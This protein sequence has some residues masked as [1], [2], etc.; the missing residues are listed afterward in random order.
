MKSILIED[1]LAVA[2]IDALTSHICVVN[3]AGII[4]AVNQAWT[5]FTA[6]NSTGR[7]VD[8]IGINYLDVCRRSVGPDSAEAPPLLKGLRAVLH[9]DKE[10]FQIEYPCH[11]PNE[12]RWYLARVSPLRDRSSPAHN[13]GAVISH[14]NITDQKLV[15][16][17]YAKLAASAV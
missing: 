4:V 3:P 8:H 9:G 12:L 7:H 1:G 16:L 5:Q 17:E 6:N 2:I 13:I 14:I 15:E 10:F 11:S